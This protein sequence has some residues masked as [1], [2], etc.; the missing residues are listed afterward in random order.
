MI[1]LIE[2]GRCHEMEV[3]VENLG[4]ENLQATIP[5]TDYD[6]STTSEECGIFHL[7]G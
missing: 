6:R 4:N 3:N 2:I 7:L 5:S 1:G